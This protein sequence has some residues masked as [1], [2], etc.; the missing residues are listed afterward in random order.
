ML[1]NR[2][3]AA[4]AALRAME[5][6]EV[7]AARHG[8]WQL[9]PSLHTAI[10]AK[11]MEVRRMRAELRVRMGRCSWEDHDSGVDSGMPRGRPCLRGAHRETLPR[12]DGTDLRHRAPDRP[13]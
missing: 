13:D 10:W 6:A 2:L 3:A 4:K 1:T 5:A 11:M 12:I 7:Y 8:K 9:M